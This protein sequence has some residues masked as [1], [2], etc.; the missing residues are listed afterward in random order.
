MGKLIQF[1]VEEGMNLKQD[2]IV[3]LVDT[4][5]LLNSFVISLLKW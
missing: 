4:T 2:Q 1:E 3:G 5:Q